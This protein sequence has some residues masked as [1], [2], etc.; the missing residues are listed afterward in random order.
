MMPAMTGSVGDF[1]DS[2]DAVQSDLRRSDYFAP[3]RQ[4]NWTITIL[5]HI[6]AAVVGL[7][8]GYYVLAWFTPRGNFL[9]LPLPWMPPIEDARRMEESLS[10]RT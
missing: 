5:G 9:D 10:S 3:T 8:I 2:S 6:L 1:D 4:R 7:L